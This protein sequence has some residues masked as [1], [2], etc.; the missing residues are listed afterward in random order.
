MLKPAYTRLKSYLGAAGN[1]T[2]IPAREV[3]DWFGVHVRFF[4]GCVDSPH[5]HHTRDL[6]DS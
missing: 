5:V 4:A 3:L 2:H 6:R 1:A